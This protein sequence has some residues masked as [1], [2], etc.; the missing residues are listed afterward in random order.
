I[1]DLEAFNSDWQERREI[2]SLLERTL[3]LF[4]F[5]S[6]P[7]VQEAFE[8][9][10]QRL[11]KAVFSRIAVRTLCYQV[12]E[13]WDRI[14]RDLHERNWS[15]L[16]DPWQAAL[17]AWREACGRAEEFHDE[18]TRR[19][20]ACDSFLRWI[21]SGQISAFALTEPSAGSDTARLVTRAVLRSVPIEEQAAC[22]SL[23]APVGATGPRIL[24]DARRLE[25]QDCVA[26]YRWSA[27]AEPAVIHFDEY[28]YETDQV[29]R[30]FFEC[31]G[32]KVYFDDIGQLRRRDDRLWYD[33]WE[34]TGGKMWITK[35][36]FGRV[37]VLYARTRA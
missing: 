26:R 8:S 18:L 4:P 27:S 25:F 32:R 17:D 23:F 35:G 10:Q 11:E 21:A 16:R 33:Y 2:R 3:K 19:R 30:R 12:V 31:E 20:D 22:S 6:F 5:P 1:R 37:V 28:D 24:L 9:V 7:S 34:V 29:K 13:K 36:R 15:D 14:G